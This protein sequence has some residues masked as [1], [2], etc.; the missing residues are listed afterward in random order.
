MRGVGRR[1][2]LGS[3]LQGR[4]DGEGDDDFGRARGQQ[5]VGALI[6]DDVGEEEACRCVD[7]AG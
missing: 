2:W 6:L 3:L 1:V 7:G 5:P 4:A